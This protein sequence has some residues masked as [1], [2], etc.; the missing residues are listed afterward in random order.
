MDL[1]KVDEIVTANQT[2]VVLGADSLNKILVFSTPTDKAFVKTSASHPP[3]SSQAW[4]DAKTMASCQMLM[5]GGFRI[6]TSN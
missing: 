5:K 1:V 6:L 3:F 2:G 4:T